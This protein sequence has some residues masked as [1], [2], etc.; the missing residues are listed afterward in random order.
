MFQKYM[1]QSMTARCIL[2]CGTPVVA[3]KSI[4]DML[5]KYDYHADYRQADI[6]CIVVLQLTNYHPADPI[7]VFA[8]YE[9]DFVT[10]FTLLSSVGAKFNPDAYLKPLDTFVT[11]L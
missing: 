7:V 11:R 9:V 4:A 5:S 1:H 8:D 3:S 10:F 2:L 6:G